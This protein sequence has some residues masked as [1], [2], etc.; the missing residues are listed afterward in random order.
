[1]QGQYYS[2][3]EGYD[4]L[5][6]N[7]AESYYEKSLNIV[8]NHF[9]SDHI[10]YAEELVTYARFYIRADDF[11]NAEPLLVQAKSI[12]EKEPDKDLF[13]YSDVII[14]L[15]STS[16]QN[17]SELAKIN[18]D[19]YSEVDI[20]EPASTGTATSSAKQLAKYKRSKPSKSKKVT[21]NKGR[22]VQLCYWSRTGN[23]YYSIESD[24][25]IMVVQSAKSL[26]QDA[27][28]SPSFVNRSLSVFKES[29]QS[30]IKFADKKMEVL[31]LD[32]KPH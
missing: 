4:G 8:R 6:K 22:D 17:I 15:K 21:L 26:G 5:Y 27:S 14:A 18:L 16:S 12:Y 9:G 24:R 2:N 20:D 11:S 3:L 13:E 7:I 29:G 10:K 32:K 25:D 1:M 23:T 31:V 30:L 28:V 19:S